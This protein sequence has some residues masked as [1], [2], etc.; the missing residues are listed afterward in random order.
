MDR[1]IRSDIRFLIRVETK[2]IPTRGIY[3]NV[4]N[5]QIDLKNYFYA[6]AMTNWKFK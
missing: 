4:S 2:E 1:K 5:E 3:I 6:Y